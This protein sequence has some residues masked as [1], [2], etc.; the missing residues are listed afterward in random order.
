MVRVAFVE[1]PD[2]LI[3]GG[4]EWDEIRRQVDLVGPDLLVANELP[5]GPWI[6]KPADVDLEV[7]KRSIDANDRGVEALKDLGVRSVI[8]SRPVLGPICLSN[9]AFVIESGKYQRLHCKHYLPNH[10][11][12]HEAKWFSP[13]SEAFTCAAVGSLTVGVLLCTE[14]MFNEHAR[15]FGR[16]GAH[17]IAVPRASG[18]NTERW[19]IAGAMAALVSGAYV[20][21]SNRCGAADDGL[22]FGGFGFAFSP[23]GDLLEHT[24]EESTIAV[25]DIDPESADRQKSQYPCNVLEWGKSK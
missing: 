16:S 8:S 23:S 25:V 7:A 4:R 19:K 10:E 18:I 15:A 5:F 22:Q 21:S 2:G 20:V 17:L 24:G 11:G 1:W 3:A 9:E 13:G 6:A 14:L 12:W